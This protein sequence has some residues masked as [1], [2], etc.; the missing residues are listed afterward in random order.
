MCSRLQVSKSGYYEWRSRPESATAEHRERLKLLIRKA[1]DRSEETYGYRRVHAQLQRWDAQA[2]P[3]LVRLLMRQM[4][5]QPCQPR[6]A[7]RCLT[8]ADSSGDIPDLI[9]RD[10]TAPQ[11]GTKLVG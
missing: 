6:P 7:R 11:P 1:F 9:Q 8:D 4:G 5:L 10:F 2:S 3:E